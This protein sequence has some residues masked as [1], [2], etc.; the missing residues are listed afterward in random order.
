MS[1]KY[2]LL[3]WKRGTPERSTNVVGVQH[4]QCVDHVIIDDP[5]MSNH[6]K[7]SNKYKGKGWGAYLYTLHPYSVSLEQLAFQLHSPVLDAEGNEIQAKESWL[8]QV[9][10]LKKLNINEN[11]LLDGKSMEIVSSLDWN[12]D[13]P[14]LVKKYKRDGIYTANDVIDRAVW[15]AGTA[16]INSNGLEDYLTGATFASDLGIQTANVIGLYKSAITET[17]TTNFTNNNGSFNLDLTSWNYH[18]GNPNSGYLITHNFSAAA[19]R[20]VATGSGL[21]RVYGNNFKRVSGQNGQCFAC[22]NSATTRNLKVFNNIVDHGG[23]GNTSQLLYVRYSNNCIDTYCNK[24]FNGGGV[25]VYYRDPCSGSTA[26][27]NTIYGDFAYGFLCATTAGVLRNNIVIGTFGMAA[28]GQIP[29]MEGYNNYCSDDS[30]EDGDFG[31]GGSGNI[32]NGDASGFLSTDVSSSD[33]LV[34]DPTSVLKFNGSSPSLALTDIQGKY[35]RTGY[36]SIGAYQF[37]PPYL[38]NVKSNFSNGESNLFLADVPNENNDIAY[39]GYKVENKF[40]NGESYILD[41]AL[42]VSGLEYESPYLSEF[43]YGESKLL[44]TSG[45]ST[46]ITGFFSYGESE[47]LHYYVSSAEGFEYDTELTEIVFAYNPHRVGIGA[48]YFPP[49][50]SILFNENSHSIY[51]GASYSNTLSLYQYLQNEHLI[52]GGASYTSS[53]E[54]YKYVANPQNVSIGAAYYPTVSTLEF[55]PNSQNIYTGASYFNIPGTIYFEANGQLVS[56]GASYNSIT[57]EFIF[58]NNVQE[59]IVSDEFRQKCPGRILFVPFDHAL[60]ACRHPDFYTAPIR[61]VGTYTAPD[62]VTGEGY[63]A[64]TRPQSSYSAPR[65]HGSRFCY[66]I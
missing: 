54:F 36:Y 25:C 14:I 57:S 23:S 51:T 53:E 35:P 59:I 56:A 30:G 50:N 3:S 17:S 22:V 20:L 7:F 60:W 10:L 29:N 11:R 33:F 38:E 55:S 37:D 21:Q 1:S 31:G 41:Y 15:T 40:S 27:N 12:L 39:R 65:R 48:A 62:R 32:T 47:I 5:W 13:D 45:D 4:L 34:T 46:T 66:P 58:D 43:S 9:E 8:D 16:N 42:T 6:V 63:T 24:F 44:H 52:G 28:F 19:V 49:Q 18:N 64:P 26:E 61:P 2:I